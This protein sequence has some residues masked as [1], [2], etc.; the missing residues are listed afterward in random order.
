MI[1]QVG[2]RYRFTAARTVRGLCG[3]DP[4]YSRA[5]TG[6][7]WS[8]PDFGT[9]RMA[10]HG[11]LLAQAER[12]HATDAVL[13]R[14]R[15]ARDQAP[16][17]PRPFW[18]EFYVA[19]LLDDGKK[20]YE[21]ARDLAR[22]AP[23]DPSAGYALLHVVMLEGNPPSGRTR[24]VRGEDA[25]ARPPLP[26]DE[27]DL[28]QRCL[29]LARPVE[30]GLGSLTLVEAVLSELERAGRAGE[31]DALYRELVATAGDL[32][33]ISVA[34]EMAAHR[35]DFDGLWKLFESFYRLP[36]GTRS[37]IIPTQG[38]IIV[39][40]GGTSYVPPITWPGRCGRRPTPGRTPRSSA[41]SIDY[42]TAMRSP[43]AGRRAKP[44]GEQV[45]GSSAIDIVM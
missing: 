41:C 4:A 20:T 10:A 45:P 32:S 35:G 5:V 29:H 43:D 7:T 38:Y 19:L 37:T 44:D 11:F 28:V 25:E 21:T 40:P 23:N 33:T 6:S 22:A 3:L 26:P 27:A 24:A 17:D 13:S 36:S 39:A 30:P 1:E 42:M 14:L 16:H 8:P 18:D 2:I 9:A 12:E 31:L 15:Q 34:S